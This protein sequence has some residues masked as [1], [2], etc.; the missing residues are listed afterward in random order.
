MK[1]R[2]YWLLPDLASAR[3]TMT[4]L[5]AAGVETRHIHF[6][7]RDGLDMTGL[8]AANV[9]QTSDVVHAAKTGLVLGSITGSCAG[10]LVALVFPIAGVE[11]QWEAA[12]VSAVVGGATGARP[13]SMIGISIPSPRLA[14][15]E[16][17]IAQGGM[18]L[19]VDVRLSL[20]PAVA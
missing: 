11:P 13:F 9:L 15:V 5:L 16:S 17:A 20:A 18:L 4:D 10:L 12:V 6:A 8:H 7:A 2:T 1:Q 14:R 19:R 3:R